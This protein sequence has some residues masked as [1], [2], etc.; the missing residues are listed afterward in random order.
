MDSII[1]IDEL[2]TK[3]DWDINNL[4]DEDSP[5]NAWCNYL[6]IEN[7]N[8]IELVKGDL[9]ILHL[10]IHSIQ[11]KKDQLIQL[12]NTFNKEGHIIDV[13]LLCETFMNDKTIN[14]SRLKNYTLAAYEYRKKLK[15]GGVAIYLRK[16]IKFINRNDLNIFKE[17][18]LESCFIEIIRNE[19][20]KNIIIGELYRIPNTSEK[21]FLEDYDNLLKKINKENK[22]L[23]IG[24]D[25]NIDYL[26]I[27]TNSNSNALFEMNLE[28]KLLPT[29]T[30]P[31]RITHQ[32]ATLIDNI[33]ISQ[34]LS[35]RYKTV[36]L[37]TDI[38]ITIHAS[39]LYQL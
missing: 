25:Q 22:E 31:T 34:N 24:T 6:E 12:I 11:A 29:V 10:N 16:G 38:L 20:K 30:R 19:K 18:E 4:V 28:H 5:L 2:Y 35:K 3:D 13:L 27:N 17:G 21:D 37:I 1:N 14:K 36:I 7:I 26:K 9:N 23:V 33:N 8:E 39:L 15:Q 32:T